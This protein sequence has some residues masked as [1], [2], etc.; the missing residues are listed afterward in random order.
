MGQAVVSRSFPLFVAL[1]VDSTTTFSDQRV[2]CHLERRHR[3]RHF[4]FLKTEA[5]RMRGPCRTPAVIGA[6]QFLGSRPQKQNK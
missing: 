2:Q 5:V 1:L 4:F 6:D 3:V